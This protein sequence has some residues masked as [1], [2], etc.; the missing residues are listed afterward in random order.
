MAGQ[1][2]VEIDPKI[3]IQLAEMLE[4]LESKTELEGCAII[5]TTG[6]RIAHAD[7]SIGPRI[8]ADLYSASPAALVSLGN[9]VTMTLEYGEVSEVVVRGQKGYSII[10]VSPS[11][12]FML[13]S[14]SKKGYKLGYFF[15]ILRKTFKKAAEL[16]Q[17]TTIG[18]ASY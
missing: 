6:L 10:T 13:L 11:V 16:L 8:D 3:Q 12:P 2:E 4:E 18:T 14:T 5:S 15:Q 1:K 7:S 17:G 9:T